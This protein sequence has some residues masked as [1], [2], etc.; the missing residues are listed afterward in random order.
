MIN[1]S[2]GELFVLVRVK[3]DLTD[4]LLKVQARQADQ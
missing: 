4:V 3:D 2:N 1:L